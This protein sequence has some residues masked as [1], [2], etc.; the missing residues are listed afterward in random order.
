MISQDHRR[1]CEATE[2]DVEAAL[3]GSYVEDDFAGVDR[4]KLLEFHHRMVRQ[5]LGDVDD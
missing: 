4:A 1:L 2:D 5:M 3:R